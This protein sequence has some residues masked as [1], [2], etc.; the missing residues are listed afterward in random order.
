M[1]ICI[2]RILKIVGEA[3]V[4]WKIDAVASEGPN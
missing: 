4:A 1:E 2:K 3:C